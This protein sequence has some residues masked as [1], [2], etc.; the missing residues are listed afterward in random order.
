[1]SIRKK[2]PRCEIHKVAKPCNQCS[3]LQRCLDTIGKDASLSRQ[4]RRLLVEA[5]FTDPRRREA[6][7]RACAQMESPLIYRGR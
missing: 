1:M 6:L 3:L 7:F 2:L 5:G 4:M